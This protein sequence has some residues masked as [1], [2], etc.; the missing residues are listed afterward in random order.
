M[1]KV[2]VAP[3]VMPLAVGLRIRQ[4][5][6]PIAPTSIPVLQQIGALLTLVASS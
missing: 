5:F 3:G 1:A 2:I 4:E 6:K